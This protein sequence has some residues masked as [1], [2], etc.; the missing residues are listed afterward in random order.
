MDFEILFQFQ[1]F[2]EISGVKLLP[3][4]IPSQIQSK[5][6]DNER[7]TV[8]A[9]DILIWNN[10]SLFT[11]LTDISLSSK[12]F[13]TSK[14]RIVSTQVSSESLCLSNAA[15]NQC[16][17]STADYD[18]MFQYY[19]CSGNPSNRSYRS[20]PELFKAVREDGKSIFES[21][22]TE[23]RINLRT[24][25]TIFVVSREIQDEYLPVSTIDSHVALIIEGMRNERHFVVKAELILNHRN[26]F[27]IKIESIDEKSAVSAAQYISCGWERE[28]D[29]VLKL[30]D[31]IWNDKNKFEDEKHEY[32][33]IY[34]NCCKYIIDK[35]ESVGIVI[36]TWE[37]FGQKVYL[38]WDLMRRRNKK[39]RVQHLFRIGLWFLIAY[40]QRLTRNDLQVLVFWIFAMNSCLVVYLF[41]PIHHSLIQCIRSASSST[42]KTTSIQIQINDLKVKL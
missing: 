15:M 1:G 42:F 4:L 16:H 18:G 23:T 28:Q 27:E 30:I 31:E 33:T 32:H 14:W 3:N 21:N 26:K 11:R 39:I 36:R 22:E 38:P 5:H 12:S 40:S 13:E 6:G 20:Y 2:Y 41:P 17:K 37:I 25:W 9:S 24:H 7:A 29:T 19:N 10:S 35:L 8:L 34:N